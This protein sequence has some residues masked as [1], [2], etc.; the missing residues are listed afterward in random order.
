M[1]DHK[2]SGA[3][4]YG[5]LSHNV[6][7]RKRNPALLV[8]ALAGAIVIVIA[9]VAIVLGGSKKGGDG[10]S[11]GTS[12]AAANATQQ[13]AAVT[14]TGT[15]LP[16][17]PE[18]AGL[19]ADAATDPAVG[20]VPP[21]LAGES[22]DG[23]KLTIDPADGRAKVVL[24]VA[25]W[26]PHCQAEVPRVQKWI[27]DGNLPKGVDLYAVA[28]S[29]TESRPNFPPSAWLASEGFS[30]KVLLDDE[31]GTAAQ[32]WGLT[33][34]PYFVMLDGDGKVVRRASGEVPPEQFDSLVKGLSSASAS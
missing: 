16:P 29:T 33:G 10:G 1:N 2:R 25:H 24:F 28:T 17:F 32:A 11:G 5:D 27:D 9:V 4:P 19:V 20:K 26:C 21:T 8:G 18:G 22:F 12:S 6:E 31:N 23:S 7:S 30:P 15:P 13:T 34:F 3:N 14:A